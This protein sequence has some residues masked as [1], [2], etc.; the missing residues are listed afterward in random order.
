MKLKYNEHVDL[1]IDDLVLFSKID[2]TW[3]KRAG[4]SMVELYDEE[5]LVLLNHFL[6]ENKQKDQP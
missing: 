5:V 6:K 3:Y 1:H 4:T 2:E